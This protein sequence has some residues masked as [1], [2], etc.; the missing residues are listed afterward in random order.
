MN[1]NYSSDISYNYNVVIIHLTDKL[2]VDMYNLIN[3]MNHFQLENGS[4]LAEVKLLH[5][6]NK[7]PLDHELLKMV[8]L[9]NL[10]CSKFDGSSVFIFGEANHLIPIS[11]FFDSNH[12]CIETDSLIKFISKNN[13]PVTL[14]S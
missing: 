10:Y 9:I 5:Y 2:S 7:K 12:D 8:D 1:D 4:I 6:K 11:N 13:L 14:K 3:Y